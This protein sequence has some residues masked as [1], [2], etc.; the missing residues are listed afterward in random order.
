MVISIGNLRKRIKNPSIA[1]QLLNRTNGVIFVPFSDS[2]AFREEHS[3]YIRHPYPPALIDIPY[4]QH[5]SHPAQGGRV[6][7]CQNTLA[8]GSKIRGLDSYSPHESTKP[9]PFLNSLP[10]RRAHSQPLSSYPFHRKFD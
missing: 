9:H 6:F 3:C 1:L 5:S 8:L 4:H 2:R 10:Q 7:T